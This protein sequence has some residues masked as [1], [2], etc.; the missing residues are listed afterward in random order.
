MDQRQ[1]RKRL[2]VSRSSPI[3]SRRL[4]R[5]GKTAAQ[6]NTPGDR[7]AVHPPWNPQLVT[8]LPPIARWLGAGLAAA[9]PIL[10][11]LLRAYWMAHGDTMV[12]AQIIRRIEIVPFVT[13]TLFQLV[14]SGVL[15]LIVISV[16]VA[17]LQDAGFAE[18]NRLFPRRLYL[19]LLATLSVAA[20]LFKPG[21]GIIPVL[22]LLGMIGVVTPKDGFPTRRLVVV[23]WLVIALPTLLS[24]YFIVV[25]PAPPPEAIKLQG[26]NPGW[27]Y[28]LTV[29]DA[30]TTLLH[31]NGGLE[32]VDNDTV[33]QRA[34]CPEWRLY[35][36]REIFRFSLSDGTWSPSIARMV[37]RS[38]GEYVSPLCDAAPAYPQSLIPPAFNP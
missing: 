18:G 19:I 38:K 30:Q 12:L 35:G 36:K 1:R 27:Y 33:T 37:M 8:A 20:I 13:T 32:I 31:V 22:F 10:I 3:L 6:R 16:R 34:V 5:G 2:H 24:L 9:I 25:T 26:R 14:Q 29:D 11:V 21:I 23:T 4:K 7:T 17:A 15:I 28:V